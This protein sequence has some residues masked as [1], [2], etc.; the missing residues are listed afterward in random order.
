MSEST[1]RTLADAE[2]GHLKHFEHY[3]NIRDKYLV[4]AL[5]TP[6]FKFFFSRNSETQVSQNLYFTDV[7]T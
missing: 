3:Q 5:R 2:V 4:R 7:F 6:V 1:G